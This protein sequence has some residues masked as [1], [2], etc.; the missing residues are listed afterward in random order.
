MKTREELIEAVSKGCAWINYGQGKYGTLEQLKVLLKE[1]FP[2]SLRHTV[3]KSNYYYADN[4]RKGDWYY[5]DMKAYYLS[6]IK[7]SEFFKE[8]TPKTPQRGDTVWVRVSA[9]NQSTKW[10][11]RRFVCYIEG[12]L[13]PIICHEDGSEKVIANGGKF[14]INSW[15]EMSLTDPCRDEKIIA[16]QAKLD[17]LIEQLRVIKEQ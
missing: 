4:D 9:G 1:C 16:L 15:N 5:S 10:V 14:V 8:S 6:P 11:R 7:L 12:A 2:C 13:N 17:E 3:G